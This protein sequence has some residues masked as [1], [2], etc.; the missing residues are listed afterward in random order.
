MNMLEHVWEHDR[1]VSAAICAAVLLFAYPAFAATTSPILPTSDGNYTQ[2][3]PSTS[4]VHY[5]MVDESVCNGTTDYNSTTV[6]SNRDSYGISLASVPS[7]STITQ[8]AIKPCASRAS[9]GGANP[10]MNVFYRANGVNSADSGGYSLT[11]TTPAD[12]ATTTYS[13]L[14][15]IKGATSTLEVGAI[16]T[17][18][19][20][21]HGARLSRVATT[22][23]YTPITAP[24]NLV[25]TAT[26][27]SSVGLTWTATTTDVTGYN[28]ERSTNGIDWT[29]V[30]S[31]SA[32][33][34][35]Y[36]SGLSAVTLYYH[37]VRAFN[38]G[39]YSS[40]SNTATTTTLA[41]PPAAPSGLSA[42]A[43]QTSPRVDLAWTDNSSDESSFEVLRSTNGILFA[44]LAST[45]ANATSLVDTIFSTSTTYWYQV[46]AFNSAGYSSVSNTAS[47]TTSTI[48]TSA[49]NI[50]LT[51]STTALKIDMNWT[52]NSSNELNFRAD[53]STSSSFS[54][55][56][57]I[58]TFAPNTTNTTYTPTLPN[59]TYFFRVLAGNG[60]G[61]TTSATASTTSAST[62]SAPSSLT[63]TATTSSAIGLT[64]TDNSSNELGFNVQRSTN[65]VNWTAVATTGANV[66]SFYDTG[67]SA[68]TH[69]FHRVRGFN[70]VGYSN[71]SNLG[72]ATTTGTTPTAP[73]SLAASATTSSAVG[74]T[75]TDNSTNETAFAVE[76]STDLSS[77]IQV[78]STSAHA[79]TGTTSYYDSGLS[80][81]T[82]YYH[83]VRAYNSVGYSSY[84]NTSAATTTDTV[85]AAPSDLSLSTAPA[86]ATTTDIT[87]NWTDNS[88]N[89]SGFTVERDSGSGFAQIATTSANAVSYLD[90]G[91]AD[92]TYTY[93]VRAYN[94]VGYSAYS[95]SAST[96]VPLPI[97]APIAYWK[98]DGD[99]TDAVGS[100]DG[101]DTGMTYSTTTGLINEGGGFDG[102][103]SELDIGHMISGTT[104]VSAAAWIKTTTADTDGGQTFIV[105]Q[106]APGTIGQMDLFICGADCGFTDGK[107]VFLATGAFNQGVGNAVLTDGN[108]HHVGFS[109]N[110]TNISLYVDGVLDTSTTM[111][112]VPSYDVSA[113]GAIGYDRRDNDRHFSGSIDEV[114]VW[115]TALSASDFA[116]LYNSG[117]G[118]QYPF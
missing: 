68:S 61:T 94:G 39:G 91:V 47:S 25:G 30:A 63:D 37:R 105:S 42:N 48:P 117:V 23:T 109:Q 88:S 70:T 104:N 50:I 36:D 33:G 98:F 99:S 53:V 3:T 85:P 62:P 6:A 5:T 97:P 80:A 56:T 26:T 108:W 95:N 14:S 27:S 55:F 24:T 87:L 82:A 96:T 118:H 107:L 92:G 89:E 90:A 15:L 71:Y 44:H 46:R 100:N 114:G 9:A 76:R 38:S 67:L 78:A 49:S 116:Q 13:G 29:G 19:S 17:S 83:R 31:T 73:S 72:S 81:N 10:V 21:M 75:W 106:L 45:S 54:V 112:S 86:S 35:Y 93:Q 20:G 111:G 8:I 34:S 52:D 57:T 43:S 51:S 1:W 7:A 69:Y 41:N 32:V 113:V 12:L 102:S 103:T 77:W 65:A 60:Y 58:G 84:S 110:G 11:G 4:T 22:I 74:I 115:D 16:L 64:W 66:S 2:W 18:T 79:A 28:V 40:Y 101:A 59:T